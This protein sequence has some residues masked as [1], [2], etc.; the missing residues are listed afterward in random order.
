MRLLLATN[1]AGWQATDAGS[2]EATMGFAITTIDHVQ[3]AAPRALE[4]EIIAFYRDVLG[5]CPIPKPAELR[6]RGGAWFQVG[7]LQLHIGLDPDMPSFPKSKR[8]VCF[9]T[10]DLAAARRAAQRAGLA[11]EEESRAEGLTRF[12]LHDP[13]G[14]R[15]EIGSRT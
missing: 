6:A 15:V 1:G 13:A 3:I 11:I 12:F 5:L 7:S 9:L 8:H 14:N 10:E 2:K 4:A